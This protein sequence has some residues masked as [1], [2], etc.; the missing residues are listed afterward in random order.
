[1]NV[2]QTLEHLT[3]CKVYIDICGECKALNMYPHVALKTLDDEVLKSPVG[4]M[5]PCLNEYND[6]CIVIEA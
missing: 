1:M 2:K 3:M 5:Y 6:V 4:R